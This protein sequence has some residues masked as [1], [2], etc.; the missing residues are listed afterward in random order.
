MGMGSYVLKEIELFDGQ[1]VKPGLTDAIALDLPGILL[2]PAIAPT[3]RMRCRW[4]C[5][6][7][8]TS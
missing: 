6:P 4:L 5:G 3:R 1:H 7:G 8:A 2:S